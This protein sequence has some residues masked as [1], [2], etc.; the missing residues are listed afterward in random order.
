MP[1]WVFA[2]GHEGRC[3]LVHDPAARKNEQDI[4]AETYA[5][6]WPE[7]ERMTRFGPDHLRAAIVIRKGLHP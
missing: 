5:V 4:A 1:H 6:P 7:F 3:I 2:F